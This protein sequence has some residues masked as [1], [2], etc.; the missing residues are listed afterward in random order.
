[1]AGAGCGVDACRGRRISTAAQA[2][3]LT[4]AARCDTVPRA[5]KAV[6][7]MEF[8][9]PYPDVPPL[10]IADTNVLGVFAAR[11][12]TTCGDPRDMI[13]DALAAPIG[14]PRIADLVRQ[15]RP[16]G[17]RSVL[18][19]VDDVSRPTPIHLVLPLLLEELHAAGVSDSG[20]EFLL[21]L[22]SHRFMTPAE[23]AAKVGADVAARYP[24]HNHDWK[25]PSVCQLIGTTAQGV[26]VWI[27]KRVARADLVIGVGRI[28]PIEVCGFTGGGKI[29][30]PGVCGKLTNDDM[31]WTRMDVPD[32]LVIGKRDNPVR[33]SIDQ[34]ARTAGLD[35]IVNLVMDSTGQIRAVVAG[36]MVDAH[37]AG[38]TL[39]LG[40]HTV[41]FPSE[42]D[43]VVADSHPFDIE[44]WQA[45]K[46]LD[47]AG[48]VVRAGGVL[49]L[50]SPCTEGFSATHREIVDLGYPPVA[51]IKRMVAEGRIA[52][53]VV[54]VHMTQVS[55]IARERATV[56]LVTTGISER[57]VKK[58][59]LEYAATPQAALERAFAVAGREAKVA[60]IRGAAEML[61][62]VGS[63]AKGGAG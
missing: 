62:I 26:D 12:C 59:G 44:F 55:R 16:G 61:P 63:A 60:L 14:T 3:V 45:N 23:I 15:K 13:R 1:M 8:R 21:A 58:V 53:K 35:F 5:S 19:V 57:D 11:E 24:V 32:H 43:I 25:D 42:A 50:V 39:A 10:S 4:P 33:A 22:G 46:A 28:M 27:N 2:C 17:V 29:L 38:C 56:I 20:V 48:L 36:D 41:R 40:V 7:P 49:I 18:I 52:S 54:A 47:Q 31:H 9:F 51:E 30:V 34:L 6:Q 37:R